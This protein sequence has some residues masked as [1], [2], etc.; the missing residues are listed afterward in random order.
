MN[1]RTLLAAAFSLGPLST[2][3]AAGT[4]MQAMHAYTLG[5]A[6]H[7]AVVYY[8]E[9]GQGYEVVTTWLAN[10]GQGPMMRHTAYLTPGEQYN[11]SLRAAGLPVEM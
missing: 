4:A 9:T 10:G 2:A 1:T 5:P 8:T 7:P 3:N 6:E 11:L